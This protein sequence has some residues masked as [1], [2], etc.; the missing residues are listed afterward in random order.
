MKKSL[1]VFFILSLLL[2]VFIAPTIYADEYYDIRHYD[3]HI[4]VDNDN[5]YHITETIDVEFYSPRHGIYRD[6]PTVFNQQNHSLKNI[7]VSN[8]IAKE[9]YQTT[10]TRSNGITSIRIGDADSYVNG[11]MTY[12]IRYTYIGGM[13]FDT[14]MDEFYFN[15]I[16]D[17]WDATID[18]VT[19]EII[20]PNPFDADSVHITSGSYGSTDTS[21]VQYEVTGTTITGLTIKP[22]VREFITIALP[23]EEGYYKEV[24][25]S[26]NLMSLF[27]F[28]LVIISITLFAFYK[29]RQY[30]NNNLII[31]VIHFEPPKNLNAPEVAYIYGRESCSNSDLGTLVLT[32]ASLGCLTINEIKKKFSSSYM[33]FTKIKDLPKTLPSYEIS[34]F[35]AMFDLGSDDVVSTKDMEHVFYTSLNIANKSLRAKF[36]GKKEIL[37]NRLQWQS[38]LFALL[39]ALF[40]SIGFSLVVNQLMHNGFITNFV[41]AIIIGILLFIVV[42]IVT[43]VFKSGSSVSKV[44]ITTVAGIMLIGILIMIYL[45]AYNQLLKILLWQNISNYLLLIILN[46]FFIL[47]LWFMASSIQYT[48]YAKE[49]LGHIEG[50]REFLKTAKTDQ[51]E[52]LY[53]NNPDYIYDIL[54]FAMVLGLTSIWEKH[55]TKLSVQSPAWY[56]SNSRFTPAGMTHSMSNSFSKAASSPTSSG[57]SSG[58]SSGGGGGGGGGGS[59]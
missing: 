23:L 30:K 27:I 6:I 54:P 46:V 45:L 43:L 59:W 29:N 51:M 48:T 32:W 12:A 58:G 17:E 34:L 33:V 9:N 35:D 41:P 19:F 37:V 4:L 38:T 10:L 22:L 39:Y 24:D 53:Q 2:T 40:Y 52:I 42:S 49:V 16:G 14:T 31:P 28:I 13:D 47:G 7:S 8:P 56:I 21:N 57:S 44:L 5:N 15:I 3:V 1:I 50:F 20:L 26:L 11:R 55:V 36:K 18:K 25:A